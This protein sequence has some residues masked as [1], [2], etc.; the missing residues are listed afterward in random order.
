MNWIKL[1]LMGTLILSP[2]CKRTSQHSD[3]KNIIGESDRYDFNKRYKSWIMTQEV[4]KGTTV[5]VFKNCED[6]IRRTGTTSSNCKG[7]IEHT[8]PLGDLKQPKE[9]TYINK[10]MNALDVYHTSLRQAQ[11]TLE[12]APRLIT[13]EYLD[14]VDIV[15]K[16]L[17]LLSDEQDH[18]PPFSY[19]AK[20][21]FVD[22]LEATPIEKGQFVETKIGGDSNVNAPSARPGGTGYKIQFS[23]YASFDSLKIEARKLAVMVVDPLRLYTSD[24]REIIVKASAEGNVMLKG[25]DSTRDDI[26]GNSSVTLRDL[27]SYGLIE[28]VEFTLETYMNHKHN[29]DAES[30]VVISFYGDDLQDSS[31]KV[32][33]K[34]SPS[35]RHVGRAS[36][37]INTFW[38][39]PLEGA[40][41]SEEYFILCGA[42]VHLD[43]IRLGL[44]SFEEKDIWSSPFFGKEILNHTPVTAT[45]YIVNLEGFEKYGYCHQKVD[46]QNGSEP[47]NKYIIV[48]QYNKTSI[49]ENRRRVAWIFPE[50]LHKKDVSKFISK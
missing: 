10:L 12:L 26:E 23:P 2:A 18:K 7:D 45:K 40:E 31:A 20:L 44:N 43:D 16:T 3:A 33:T 1:T 30:E 39:K 34:A 46:L 8:L 19:Q 36:Q 6:K 4:R 50:S 15:E 14:K 9:G 21:P 47:S 41:A 25:D 42:Y 28:R 22:M 49:D 27:S 5:V 17:H 48:A 37:K 11:A 29:K 35:R 32:A 24:G 38:D 13:N